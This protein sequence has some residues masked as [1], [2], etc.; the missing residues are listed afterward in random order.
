MPKSLGNKR[1]RLGGGDISDVIG[2]YDAFEEG[3]R[4][5]IR[6]NEFFMYRRIT[7]DRPLR[8]RYEVDDE[9]VE[10]LK[11]SRAFQRLAV[12]A[13]N[14]KDP[15]AA[16]ASG[17]AAQ[18]VIRDAFAA[19][20]G[21]ET[22]DRDD[23][24]KIV[25]ELLRSI[26]RPTATLRKAVLDALSGRDPEAPI[27]TDRQGNAEP[28]PELRDTE[29]VPLGVPIDDYIE[30]EVLPFVPD[31]W[32]DDPKEKI[33]SEIPLTQLFYRYEPPRPIEEID[34]DIE[35]LEGYIQKLTRE[36]TA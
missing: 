16:I 21:L 33:G 7:V 25:K 10:R 34:S 1:R 19:Q 29:N 2:L 31:A 27:V 26:E 36:V 30:R 24:E 11:Q 12:P 6:Q 28:D 8:L 23:A 9:A 17:E 18:A 3:E 22:T 5:K 14:V 35:Q 15:E 13:A 32:V 4:S 20:R